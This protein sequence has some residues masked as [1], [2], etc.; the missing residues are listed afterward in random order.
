MSKKIL[1]IG[2]GFSSLAASCYLAKAGYDVTIIEKNSEAGGRAR[3]LKKNGFTFDIGPT[4]YWMP[5]VFEKFFADFGKIPAD[6][7]E[8]VKLNPG[9]QVY[10]GKND[11][12]PI[13][14]SVAKIREEFEKIEKGS[15]AKLDK[16]MSKASDNYEIAINDLVYKPAQNIFELVSL[17]TIGK[18]NYFVDNIK[19]LVERHI[20][21]KRL[22][23]ILQFPVL[24]LG[25]KPADTP[26]FYNF[27]N[28]ADFGLGTWHPRGGMYMVVEALIKLAKGLG[29]KIIYDSPA[30]KI[31]VTDKKA[32][33]LTSGDQTY[34]FDILLSGADY[35]HTETLLPKQYRQYSESY[36]KSRTFAPS[37]LL[38]Y[39]GFDKEIKN[40]THHTLFFDTD[41]ESHAHTIY[42]TITYP[43]NPLFYGSFPSK[44]DDDAAPSG[45][46]AGII[47][48]PLAPGLKEDN[49]AIRKKYFDIVIE[50]LESLTG[51]SLRDDVLFYE[52][53]SVNDFISQYNSY[54]GNAYGLATTLLQTH[55]LRPRL[56]SRKVKNL[57]FTGQLTVPGPGVPPSLISGQIVSDLI[58]KKG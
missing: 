18:L 45:K 14:D 15:S 8:L 30:D 43:E 53:F 46:E 35:H 52:S 23:M 58:I 34:E 24:F 10:F 50:R 25:A 54:K 47:L 39:I 26:A 21:D 55:I 51:Q 3:Q 17:K 48:I 27:M 13:Y 49:E 44:T 31:N 9:Y 11:S 42:D 28:Y 2:S 12:I 36:W 5:D 20:N 7:Y 33:S 19:S 4:F 38:F 40:V 22:R 41:F 57:Y 37:A 6:Y 1:I 29:V 56:K 16:F 32:V